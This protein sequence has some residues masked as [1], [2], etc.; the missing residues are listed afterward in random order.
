ME[1]GGWVG[2]GVTLN[3]FNFNFFLEIRPK[4]LLIFWSSLPCV[5]CV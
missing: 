4:I 3:F 5:F 2:A 1:E